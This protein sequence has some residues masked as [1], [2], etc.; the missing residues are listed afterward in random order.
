MFKR[1]ETPILGIVENMAGFTCDGCGKT[2]YPFGHGGAKAEA[3]RLGV[4]FLG[5]VP[6]HLHIREAGDQGAPIV[7]ARPE[8][9]E[10]EGFWAV[11]DALIETLE[12]A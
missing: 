12:T 7:A 10:A 4:P 11:A 8:S 3:E 5:E 1:L 9:T 2:H 6:L